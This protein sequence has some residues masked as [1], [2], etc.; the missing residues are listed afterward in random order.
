LNYPF[1]KIITK[2]QASQAKKQAAINQQKEVYKIFKEI[3]QATGIE[4]MRDIMNSGFIDEA[5]SA[6]KQPNK[7]NFKTYA[8]QIEAIY[9]MYFAQSDY[10]S[11]LTRGI[12]DTRAGLIFGE[13]INVIV[14]DSDEGK[15]KKKEKVQSLDNSKEIDSGNE[16]IEDEKKKQ[17]ET[18]INQFLEDNKLQGEN[19]LKIGEC[20]EKE[21]KVLLALSVITKNK[22]KQ[23][24]V[25]VITFYRNNYKINRDKDG[26]IV[27][28]T[29]KVG[30][31][32]VTL[33]PH[34]FV[35]IKLSGIDED[36][37]NTPPRIANVLTQIENYSRAKYDLRHNNHLFAKTTPFFKTQDDK[38]A[39]SINN[40]IRAKKWTIGMSY[41]G[42]A[43]FDYKTA[44]TAV[45]ETIRQERVMDLKDIANS[46]GIPV[47]FNDPELLSNKA[48]G[49][50]MME[51][52]NQSTKKERL[53]Y[54]SAMVEL[55]QK[56]MQMAVDG[57]IDGAIYEPDLIDVNIPLITLD[58]LKALIETWVVLYEKKFIS[59]KTVQG[60]IPGINPIDE[61]RQIEEET[62]SEQ[63]INP[64]VNSTMDELLKE[65]QNNKI[66][67]Q[68]NTNGDKTQSI[69]NKK[70]QAFKHRH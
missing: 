46:A 22:R 14:H 9:K 50:T 54:S 18:F 39:T 2:I 62:K 61:E 36:D 31:E 8:S 11:E 41:A 17:I 34:K 25:K 26:E 66:E 37:E 33:K 68:E 7:N 4:G 20:G 10:G 69:N 1:K 60:K 3:V 67:N 63:K 13:G 30:T 29:Y 65:N 27:D 52:V 44:P 43:D 6:Q 53:I 70:V 15:D 47:F 48:L 49:E 45:S 59:K 12:I 64:D 16:T 28:V 57:S 35:F 19:A 42:P 23:I 5:M 51:M 32:T 58:N 56:A 38:Q 40:D 24:K 55:I 21:G